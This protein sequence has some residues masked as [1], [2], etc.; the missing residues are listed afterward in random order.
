MGRYS[1][2]SPARLQTAR[3]RRGLGARPMPSR[4]TL[5]GACGHRLG[6]RPTPSR[7]RSLRHPAFARSEKTSLRHPGCARF[8]TPL[9][10]HGPR[11][12]Q[13]I[14]ARS[15][16]HLVRRSC[17][18][19][20]VVCDRFS[21]P[22]P[23]RLAVS[24]RVVVGIGQGHLGPDVGEPGVELLPQGLGP[25]GLLRRRVGCG[26]V[27]VGSAATP[28]GLAA[29][30]MAPQSMRAIVAVIGRRMEMPEGEAAAGWD[31]SVRR[32]TILGLWHDPPQPVGGPPS[33]QRMLRR[34]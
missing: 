34:W 24:G 20:C 23:L 14:D 11:P 25:L 3:Q 29:A 15:G 17:A 33:S 4:R 31:S 9:D 5:G 21:S 16:G 18:H 26:G 7:G 6:A 28:A 27:A 22:L 13:S 19:R 8:S 1:T 12:S 10:W 30:R 2:A 32:G